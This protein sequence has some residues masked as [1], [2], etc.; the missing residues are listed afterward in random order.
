MITLPL[1]QPTIMI[2]FFIIFGSHSHKNPPLNIDFPLIIIFKIS[3]NITFGLSHLDRLD[4]RVLRLHKNK[5]INKQVTKRCVCS[6][7]QRRVHVSR[8]TLWR[9]DRIFR[10]NI[11]NG[12]KGCVF[13]ISPPIARRSKAF[14]Q[15]KTLPW[16]KS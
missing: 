1:A 7:A 15:N 10:V 4:Y 12:R 13:I 14:Q 8:P 16:D 6:S 5:I 3:C 2:Q 11:N 9:D